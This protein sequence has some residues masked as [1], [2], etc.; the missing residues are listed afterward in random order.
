MTPGPNKLWTFRDANLKSILLRFWSSLLEDRKFLRI[1]F[2]H[3][4]HVA[5]MFGPAM[6]SRTTPEMLED[7]ALISEY[8]GLSRCLAR[9]YH[10][11]YAHPSPG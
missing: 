6:T 7:L 2:E 8:I 10:R 5:G 4:F 1:M 9:L 11:P 3:S